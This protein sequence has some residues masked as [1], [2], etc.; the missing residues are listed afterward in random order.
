MF[1]L[2][3]AAALVVAL[4]G[5]AL[6]SQA[7]TGVGLIA[8]ACLLGILAR[9]AQAAYY[10]KADSK[11]SASVAGKVFPDAVHRPGIETRS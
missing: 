1:E 3:I 8:I 9:I 10:R 7:T 2:L 4:A 6:L 5:V 11:H